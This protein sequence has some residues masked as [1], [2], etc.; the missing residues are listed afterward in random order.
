MPK[1]RLSHWALVLVA[2][3]FS[4]GLLEAKPVQTIRMDQKSGALR[5]SVARF[6][7]GADVSW[8][9]EEEHAGLTFRDRQGNKADCLKILKQMGITC[10]RLRVWVNPTEKWCGLADT[11][12]K[13]KRAVALGQRVLIDFQYS[14]NWADPSHQPM[15]SAWFKH[16]LGQLQNDVF[17][18]TQATLKSL[19]SNGIP[20]SYV[21]VGNEISGGMMWPVGRVQGSG[22]A[23]FAPLTSLLNRGYD[24]VKSV[25]PNAKVIIHLNNG[26]D[27]KM[28]R[29]FFDGLRANK[30]KWDVIGMSFYPGSYGSPIDGAALLANQR[31]MI[32][33]YGTSVCVCELGCPN[34]Q[35]DTAEKIISEV[36]ANTKSLGDKGLGVFYWEPQAYPHWHGYNLGACDAN[37]KFTNALRALRSP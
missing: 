18:H 34:D 15:P 28:F 29:W 33:R 20:V 32:S 4:V 26:F 37:G 14:D 17:R 5:P 8:L 25:Y 16:S 22:S 1:I 36:V 35:P 10:I 13:A 2:A 7:A 6:E 11:I 31:D 30:G 24:A 12:A 19:K 3:V 21:Q 9:T 27:N 23:V